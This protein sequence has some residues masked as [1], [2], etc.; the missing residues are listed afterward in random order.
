M[1][2]TL[3]F[4]LLSIMLIGL[5]SCGEG[6]KSYHAGLQD[7]RD[8]LYEEALRHYRLALSQGEN[9]PGIYADMAMACLALGQE[10]EAKEY[11]AK[12]VS[13]GEKDPDVMTRAGIY[14]ELAGDAQNALFYYAQV[15]PSDL[16]SI[17]QERCDACGLAADIRMRNGEYEEAIRL[18]NGL[19]RTGY[20]T[21]EH[22]ILAGLCFLK[23]HQFQAASQYF[24]LLAKRDETT[25]WH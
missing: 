21:T 4:L 5:A 24:D 13:M 12:A 10:E 3:L 9:A 19:I 1:K 16:S 2:K 17:P 14:Y 7:Y 15:I 8:G 25:P 20:H 11:I 18:Y 22:I 6:R 23:E